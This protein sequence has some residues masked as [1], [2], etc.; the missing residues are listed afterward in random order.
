VLLYTYTKWFLAF[1]FRKKIMPVTIQDI[2]QQLGIA[3]STVSKALND[4]S[5][6]SEATRKRVQAAARELGYHPSAAAQSLRRRKTRKIGLVVNYPIGFIGEYLSRLMIGVAL[7]A[8]REGYHIVL[9]TPIAD[10]LDQLTRI[11]RAREVDGLLLLWGDLTSE[12]LTIMQTENIPFVVVAR[13]VDEYEVPFV[14]G[15]NKGGALELTRH[16]LSLGHRRIGFTSWDTE[17]TTNLDRLAG[18]K[19]ALTEANIP[20]DDDLVVSITR[21]PENRYAAMNTLLDLP[22]PPTAVFAFHDYVAIQALQAATD[23]GL[24]VPEDVA[25][26]GFDGMYSS[27][28]TSPPL[29]TVKHPVREIGQR[30]VEIVLEQIANTEIL[31]CQAILPVELVPRQSTLGKP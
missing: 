24:R 11:C 31:P 29:T 3:A 19:Q 9:Y 16:L 22:E 14:V 8:E 13:R 7:A 27:L 15:D 21:E 30:A 26:A 4:Y 20:F 6:V 18:Y 17:R 1:V 25:I 10:P 23:R 12:N 5:D 2:A 28:I